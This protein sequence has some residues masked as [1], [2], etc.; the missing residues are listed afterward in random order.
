MKSRKFIVM[1][2]ISGL[3]IGA[4]SARAWAYSPDHDALKAAAE[5]T[6]AKVSL[7]VDKANDMFSLSGSAPLTSAQAQYSNEY[8]TGWRAF[9][10]GQYEQALEHLRKA[11]RIIRSMPDWNEVGLPD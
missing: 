4:P 11:D 10:K 9:E 1:A 8:M 7:D 5:E 2:L 6:L 3:A